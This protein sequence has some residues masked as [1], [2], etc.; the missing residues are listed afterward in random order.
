MTAKQLYS[1]TGKIGDNVVIIGGGLSGTEMGLSYAEEGHH[2]TVIEM[3]D[4]IAVEANHIHGPAIAET[5][6]RLKDNITCLTNTKCT[7]VKPGEVSA[8]ASAA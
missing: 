4:K 5:I 2:V 1:Y 7:A 3:R 8:S 6:E